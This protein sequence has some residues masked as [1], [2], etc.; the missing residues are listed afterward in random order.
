MKKHAL[1]LASCLICALLMPLT[2]RGITLPG[3]TLFEFRL[4]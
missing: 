2:A 3:G 1:T 4:T